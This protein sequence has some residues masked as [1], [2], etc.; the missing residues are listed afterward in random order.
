MRDPAASEST[1]RASRRDERA[2]A[3]L[4][5]LVYDELRRLARGYLLL[6]VGAALAPVHGLWA[7]F[8]IT[9]AISSTVIARVMEP[10]TTRA[11]FLHG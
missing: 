3:E 1:A 11:A 5:P 8:F 2:L 7:A 4:M 10:A 6:A 9:M